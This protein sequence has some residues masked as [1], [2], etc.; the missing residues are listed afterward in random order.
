MMGFMSTDCRWKLSRFVTN[1]LYCTFVF[2]TLKFFHHL[3]RLKTGISMSDSK[4]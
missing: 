3:Y 1:L 4:T 2:Q